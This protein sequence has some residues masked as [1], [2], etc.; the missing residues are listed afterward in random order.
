M[1]YHSVT[2]AGPEG[3]DPTLFQP[4]AGMECFASDQPFGPTRQAATQGTAEGESHPQTHPAAEIAMLFPGKHA[5]RLRRDTFA[6]YSAAHGK[7]YSSPTEA[8][9]RGQ[10][11]HRS[12]RHIN[13]HNRQRG[14]YWLKAT[15]FADW[16]AE[17]RA[18]LNGARWTDEKVAV[19]K[20]HAAEH[21]HNAEAVSPRESLSEKSSA[22][23]VSVDWRKVPAFDGGTNRGAFT[24][25]PKDQGTCGSCWSFG[26][27]GTI[28]GALARETSA[29]Q[30]FPTEVSQ[31]N[32][33]DCSWKFGNNACDG[34]LDWEGFEWMIGA[35]KSPTPTPTLTPSFC[36]SSR[37]SISC[38]CNALLGVFVLALVQQT[39]ADSSRRQRA[40]DRT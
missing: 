19:Y 32:L 40:T 7:I 21:P 23:P 24:N 10:E 22:P 6:A 25:P 2:P 17:E 13:A 1:D 35:L 36:Q 12:L 38:H 34:G 18:A 30:P 14:S 27:T 29:A 28:E 26:A 33:L 15:R 11:F 39:T 9:L 31:Q 4:P 37:Y 5:D 8:Y 3:L 20:T 16:T